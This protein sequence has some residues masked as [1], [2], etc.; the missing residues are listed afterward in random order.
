MPEQQIFAIDSQKLDS[1]ESCMYQYM[2][3]FGNAGMKGDHGS[4][5]LLTP[6]YYE[7]GS[8]V[9]VMLQAYYNQKKHRGNWSRNGAT[10]RSVVEACVNIGRYTATKMLLDIAEIEACIDAFMQYTDFWENDGW[11]NIAFTEKVG[12]KILFKSPEL[13]V[14]YEVKIDL[15]LILQGNEVTPVDHKTAKARRDP[16]SLS[17]QFRGYCWFLGVNKIIVNE[18][19]FQKTVKAP[20]KFRRHTLTY[21]ESQITEWVNNASYWACH[22]VALINAGVYPQNFTSCDKY[23]GCQFKPQICTTDPEVREF[24]LMQFFKPRTWDVG[25]KDL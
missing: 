5:P 12:S 16:N 8:L 21:S 25:G 2:L 18:V 24:K 23:S 7:K 10:H 19:G 22:A 20:D 3:K 9:H 15:G 13:L 11:T 14:L 17:N 4:T 1:I 6:D